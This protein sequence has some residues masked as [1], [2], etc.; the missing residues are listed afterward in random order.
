MPEN[1][2]DLRISNVWERL[3]TSSVNK[4]KWCKRTIKEM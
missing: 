1:K 2:V 4:I 3:K